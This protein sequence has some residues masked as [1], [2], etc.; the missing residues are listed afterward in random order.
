LL[1]WNLLEDKNRTD[2]KIAWSFLK[3]SFTTSFLELLNSLQWF[4]SG[5]FL[6]RAAYLPAQFLQQYYYSIFFSYG[7]FLALHGKGHYTVAIEF[8]GNRDIS[9]IRKELWFSEGPPPFIGIKSKGSGGE[10]EV[11]A[12]W[13][14]E[15]F[16]AWDQSDSYPAVLLFE[17]DRAFHTGFRNMFTYALSGMAEELHHQDSRDPISNEI[18]LDLWNGNDELVDYFP[19]VFWVLEHLRVP[20]EIHSRL[21]AEHKSCSPVTPKQK[22]LLETLINR[23]KDTGVSELIGNILQPL[24]SIAQD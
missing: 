9:S 19:E 10:H 6:Q 2:D 22:Y 11:R 18:I 12:N 8:K 24:I 16:K 15:V 14:Y 7:S 17:S 4:M 21:I 23:H 1:D 20:L 3:W 5:I 13:Y